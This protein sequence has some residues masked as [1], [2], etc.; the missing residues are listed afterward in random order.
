MT[1][2]EEKLLSRC[3]LCP[4]ACGAARLEGKPGRCGGGANARLARAALHYWEEPCISGEEGSGTVFFSGCALGC[5]Y[6]QNHTISQENQGRE[7]SDQ[8][9][10][11]IFLEL[12]AQGANNINLVTAG[13]YLP[14]VL[15]ALDLARPQ[16]HIPVVYNSSGY[17][18]VE[19][20]RLLEGYVDIYL[21]DLKYLDPRRAGAYSAAPDYPQV[22]KAALLEMFRQV[23]PVQWD[24]RGMLRRGMIVR[25]LVLP[26]GLEDTRA[27]L[28]W[29]AEN[30][31]LEQVLISV[32]SQYTPFYHS[33]RFPELGRRLSQ[34]EYDQ[35]LDLL[36]EL[37]I[38]EGFV[39]ELSSA[40]EEY[41]PDFAL[42]GVE[43]PWQEPRPQEQ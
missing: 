29:L 40:K 15:A 14:Q 27:A 13:H 19:S 37:G 41:T 3:T 20:L 28:S 21:P 26:Q 9:L 25:H 30:L 22:A 31:P 2:L 23:G 35:V 36:E 38:E 17:E 7:V 6:C 1:P 4:R 34:E 12:Q 10:A 43:S 11:Q 5:C 18:T 39:Q 42:Q 8:R 16:L 24:E 33:G 32:M